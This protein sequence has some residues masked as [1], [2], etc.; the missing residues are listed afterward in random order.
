MDNSKRVFRFG[1]NWLQ[2]F[3]V[4]AAF[5]TLGTLAWASGDP[6][7]EKPYTQWD[8]KDIQRVLSSSP[9]MR[10]VS[11][12]AAWQTA[13]SSYDMPGDNPHPASQQPAT[14][15]GGGGGGMGGGGKGAPGGGGGGGG[16]PSSMGA[17]APPTIPQAEFNVF[18]MSSR[19]MRGAMGRREILHSGKDAAEV[20]TFVNKPMDE[21]EIVVQGRDMNPFVNNDEKFFQSN[22]FLEIKKSKEKVSPSHVTFERGA[23]G[24]TVTGAFFF[25][26]KKSASGE[27]VIAPDEKS[28]QFT[29]SLGKSILKADFDPRKMDDQKGPDL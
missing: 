22:A 14:P 15:S 24:K 28:V 1:D 27:N 21:Y 8:D 10:S 18:W 3:G 9:W 13:P 4:M 19:T 12:V 6:W 11:V 5:L 29:V 25:F 2:Q 16:Q 23:N 26:P 17:D 7:K 20:D